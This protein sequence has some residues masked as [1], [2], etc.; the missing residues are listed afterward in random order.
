MNP[1]RIFSFILIITMALSLTNCNKDKKIER[2]LT[3]KD[4]VWNIDNVHWI[5]VDQQFSP[6]QQTISEGTTNNAGT[7]T[8][9]DDGSGSYNYSVGGV[10]RAGTFTYAVDDEEIAIVNVAQGWFPVF[11]QE[12]TAYAGE[13]TSKK[14]LYLE[15]TETYQDTAQQYVFTGEFNLSR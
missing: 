5:T 2:Q 6:I 11:Y 14:K 1:K 15:G 9:D 4:G 8:F 12:A 3:K 10:N 13:Q 7:F